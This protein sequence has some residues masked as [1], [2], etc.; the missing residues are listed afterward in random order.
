M[1]LIN[2]NQLFEAEKI[3]DEVEVLKK[4]NTLHRMNTLHELN[5]PK[6]GWD[7]IAAVISQKQMDA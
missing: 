7:E 5:K 3:K 1:T 6:V 4:T 2:Y